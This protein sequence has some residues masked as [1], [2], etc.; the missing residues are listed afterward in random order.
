MNV[1]VAGL[2]YDPGASC[3]YIC[4]NLRLQH[5]A[6]AGARARSIVD[7]Q[8]GQ[9]HIRVSVVLQHIFQICVCAHPCSDSLKQSI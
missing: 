8:E 2:H 9:S 6:A 1:T 5:L 4:L 7:L 3:K